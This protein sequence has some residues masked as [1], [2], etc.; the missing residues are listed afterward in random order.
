MSYVPTKEHLDAEIPQF[1]QQVNALIRSFQ[2]ET[3]A[4]DAAVAALLARLAEKYQPQVAV[5]DG[6]GF[7]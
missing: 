6:F 5:Q 3:G 2:S 4:D 7:R 1:F